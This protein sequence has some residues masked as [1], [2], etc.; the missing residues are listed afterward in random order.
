MIFLSSV[1]GMR[2]LYRKMLVWVRGRAQAGD[3]KSLYAVLYS[4]HGNRAHIAHSR[5]NSCRPMRQGRLVRADCARRRPSARS[6]RCSRCGPDSRLDVRK[7]KSSVV[8]NRTQRWLY[9]A[10][11]GQR[12]R[13]SESLISARKSGIHK[14]QESNSRRFLE[15][16]AREVIMQLICPMSSAAASTYAQ[17]TR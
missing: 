2:T 17:L 3:A 14:R 5:C 11:A 9:R 13:A 7:T 8:A 16:A 6:R 4:F 10:F 12:R 1:V 15:W